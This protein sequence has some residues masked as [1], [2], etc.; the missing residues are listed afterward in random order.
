MAIKRTLTAAVPYSEG[1]KVTRWE[2]EMQYEQGTEGEADYYTNTKRATINAVD[3]SEG[4]DGKEVVVN[5]FT[6][7]A[8]AD[9]SKSDLEAL[10][11]T[12]QWDEVF[13]SQYDSV[14]TN[15][16]KEPVPDNSYVIP[17]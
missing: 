13:A 11:P 3:K 10:C 4:P 16:P 2:L 12:T 1:G 9:W 14:I 17:S 6:A 5:N 15:P 7:K 8:E